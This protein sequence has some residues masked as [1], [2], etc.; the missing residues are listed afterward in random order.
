[1]LVRF[2]SPPARAIMQRHIKAISSSATVGATLG[3]IYAETQVNQYLNKPDDFVDPD[4]RNTLEKA[5]EEVKIATGYQKSIVLKCWHTYSAD[6]SMEV[7][8]SF[9]SR[10][11]YLRIDAPLYYARAENRAELK[12]VLTHEIGGHLAS[13]HF[14]K[15]LA[16]PPAVLAATGMM[17]GIP[18]LSYIPSNTVKMLQVLSRQYCALSGFK[19]AMAI[20][21]TPLVA[22][23]AIIKAG[24]ALCNAPILI[25]TAALCYVQR[26][27]EYVADNAIVRYCS[28]DEIKSIIRFLEDTDKSKGVKTGLFDTHPCPKDRI[29][30]I[31]KQMQ[32]NDKH[33]RP[34]LP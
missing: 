2:F 27:R 17:I 8:S 34:K 25:A 18:L 28:R 22:A 9:F 7:A 30:N 21:A 33:S 12:A 20:F 10:A 6:R 4:Y 16:Y 26:Q 13:N 29:E 31:E 19:R 32:E 3:F 11:S 5:V 14:Q 24:P 15:M 23:T 1:M